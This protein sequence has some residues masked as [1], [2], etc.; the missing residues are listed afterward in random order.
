M[1]GKPSEAKTLILLS[2]VTLSIFAYI[3]SMQLIPEAQ[4]AA[5]YTGAT[6]PMEFYLHYVDTPVDVAGLQTKYVM[7]TTRWFHF[8]TQQDAYANS[9]YKPTGQPKIAVDFYLYPNLA[10]PVTFNGTWQVFVWVNSSAY[11]P[12]GFT[13]QFYEITVGGATLW[14]SGARNPTVTSSVGEYID[15]PVY[16]YNLSTSLTHAFNAG[17]TL[18]VHLEVNAGSSAD[19]RI[20]YDS[21]S[22]PSKLI[23]PAQDYARPVS[24]KTY[25]YDNSETNMFYNNWSDAQRIVIIRATVTDPF[26]GYDVNRVN[27][28]MLDPSST[29]V[30]N[31]VDMVRTSDGQWLTRFANT[32]EY[33]WTYPST[34]QLGNYT[35][36]V[37]V[38][39]NNGYYR[40]VGTGSFE[41]FIEHDDHMFQM[42]FVVYYDPAF[43]IVDAADAPLP[44]AQV[45]VTWPNGTREALPRYTDVN[46][47]IN[48][49][50]VLPANY[51]FTILWK[52][53]LVKQQNVYVDSDGP[54]TIKTEVY[55]LTITVLGNNGAAVH[56]AYVIVY[57]QA[58][59]GYGLDITDLAGQVVF[60]LPKG[61]YNIEAHFSAEYWLK[62]VTTS[63]TDSGVSVSAATSR[64]LLLSEFPPPIWTTTGFWLIIALVGVTIFA[65]VYIVFLS[66]RHVPAVRKRT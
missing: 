57:T 38:I 12:A 42:G 32:F 27:M 39:D 41:P 58:G 56:G 36:N 44:R 35:V 55:Q 20:W 37:S 3:A 17:T 43:Q 62:V 65:A 46:G 40:Y 18:Q 7:N 66:R 33:N 14:D 1:S 52:D 13:L 11:K 23:L 29:P 4:A 15:V 16:N 9:F 51:G 25:A 59:V 10:G 31:N 6:K 53:V 8:L 45:Y 47:W 19:T 60:K 61:T 50:H 48:L 63:T 30:T 2:V 34:A 49:T 24:M 64:T 26:G 5:S 22:Y 54:Y 21:S 28:T